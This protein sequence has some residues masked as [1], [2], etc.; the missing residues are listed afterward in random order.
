MICIAALIQAVVEFQLTLLQVKHDESLH[1]NRVKTQPV[2]KSTRHQQEFL[3][4]RSPY[5]LSKK[6][7]QI[8]PFSFS[9]FIAE[10]VHNFRCVFD[11][12]EGC[13]LKLLQ[14]TTMESAH[15]YIQQPYHSIANHRHDHQYNTAAAISMG[16]ESF[17][18]T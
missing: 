1:I 17:L 15:G 3:M 7:Q 13:V 4:Q 18:R 6:M 5:A 2:F 12:V 8:R 14:C 9:L 10:S 11:D 16:R